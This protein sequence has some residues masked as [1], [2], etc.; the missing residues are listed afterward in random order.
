MSPRVR[1]PLPRS[2]RMRTGRGT[3]CR[4][5]NPPVSRS[6]NVPPN[7]RALAAFRAGRVC[8]ARIPISHCAD[9]HIVTRCFPV[10]AALL[11]DTPWPGLQYAPPCV[12]YRP[13]RL[14]QSP[15]GRLRWAPRDTG[16]AKSDPIR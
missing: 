14:V 13:A 12:A 1:V 10:S 3:G 11:A 4:P 7:D 6:P 9:A 2:P 8:P 5:R 16:A 15:G